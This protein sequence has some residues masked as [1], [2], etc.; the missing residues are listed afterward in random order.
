[1]VNANEVEEQR[2]P[3]FAFIYAFNFSF[4]DAENR[5]G[6]RDLN[7]RWISFNIGM[8]LLKLHRNEVPLFFNGGIRYPSDGG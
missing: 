8:L 4:G 6:V 2:R 7:L 5:P 3:N 1:M